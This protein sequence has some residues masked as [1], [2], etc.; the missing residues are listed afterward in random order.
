MTIRFDFPD[1]LA[2]QASAEYWRSVAKPLLKPGGLLLV[3]ACSAL[4][5]WSW[6]QPGHWAWLLLCGAG[7][8]MYLAALALWMGMAFWAPRAYLAKLRHLPNR[9]FELTLADETV[10]MRSAT[11]RLEVAW[12]ELR[13]L[14][15]LPSFFVLKLKGGAELPVPRDALDTNAEA[16]LVAKAR[17]LAAGG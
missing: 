8:A 16:W 4:F 15:A 1:S 17:A 7:P 11:E 5:V 10:T 6:T 9:S 3:A 14:L 2:K 13:Q 12:S